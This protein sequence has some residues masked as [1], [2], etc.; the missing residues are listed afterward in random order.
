MKKPKLRHGKNT[1]DESGLI[2]RLDRREIMLDSWERRRN[3]FNI[4]KRKK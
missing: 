4:T 1:I 2:V 3:Q